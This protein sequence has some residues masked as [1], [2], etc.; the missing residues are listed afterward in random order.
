ME[1]FNIMKSW[2]DKYKNVCEFVRAC[3][4]IRKMCSLRDRCGMTLFNNGKC[5]KITDFL[6]T[7]NFLKCFVLN[8]HV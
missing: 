2:D 7:G 1:E 8:V 5:S 3:E 4:Q 6:C